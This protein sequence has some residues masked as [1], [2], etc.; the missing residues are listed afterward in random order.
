MG[1]ARSSRTLLR[2]YRTMR[3]S[4][5]HYSL[6]TEVVFLRKVGS[7][8]PN[9]TVSHI[10]QQNFCSKFQAKMWKTKQSGA[11]V[12]PLLQWRSIKNDILWVCIC[13]LRYPAYSYNAHAPYCHLWPAP[14]YSIFPH[15]L[16]KDTIFQNKKKKRLNIKCVFWF[17]VQLLPESFLIL[18]RNKQDNKKFKLVFTYSTRYSCQILM[19]CEFSPQ[20]FEECCNIKFNEY[21]TGRSRAVPCGRT[22]RC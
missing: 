16:I 11:F 17:S 9:H 10:T 13:S 19:K 21:P 8:L 18:R 3:D 22:W 5:Q 15:Y 20:I 1:P 14:L 2:I 4:I 12:Q 7:Y 6:D